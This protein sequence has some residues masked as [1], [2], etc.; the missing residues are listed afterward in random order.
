MRHGQSLQDNLA[1]NR[2]Y[3]GVRAD[4]EGQGKHRDGG[5]PRMLR[6]HPRP[7]PNVLPDRSHQDFPGKAACKHTASAMNASTSGVY[8]RRANIVP[9]GGLASLVWAIDVMRPP[10]R[11]ETSPADE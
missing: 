6:Q 9:R 7:E 2:K 3:A 4:A 10:L 11:T 5:E 1:Q 8:A